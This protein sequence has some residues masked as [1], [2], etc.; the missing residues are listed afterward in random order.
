[1]NWNEH[2]YPINYCDSQEYWVDISE[3]TPYPGLDCESGPVRQLSMTIFVYRDNDG[4]EWLINETS[5]D[6][7]I[8]LINSVYSPYG[9]AFVLDEIIWVDEAYPELEDGFG[10]QISL[11]ELGDGFIEGYN[12]SNVNIVMQSTGWGA[13]SMFPWY[14]REYYF[15][16][17][18]AS[19][20]ATSY[21]PSHELGHFLGLYH[22]HQ[23]HD[24]PNSDSDLAQAFTWTQDW[25]TP[26]EQCYRTG[27][28]IC[29][30]PYDCY[31]WCEEVINCTANA[32]ESDRPDQ[33]PSEF[34][35]CTLEQ[36]N[37]SRTNL[38][39]RYGD[40]SE[41][42]FDQGARARYFIQYMSENKREGNLLQYSEMEIDY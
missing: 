7:G 20:F 16:T 24:D 12:Q 15:S 41:I 22:T 42:S 35:N 34:A 18:R 10:D 6:T 19:T 31:I 8:E 2:N 26:T 33:E 40:R 32:Y 30:T 21:V 11:S 27:D 17:V 28:F 36:H 13:Y 37:P 14:T 4:V 38:M 23:F 3:D 29:S 1:L 9:I 39:S 25:I 5:I